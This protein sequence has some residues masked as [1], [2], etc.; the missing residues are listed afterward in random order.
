M[1]AFWLTMLAALAVTA[2][3]VAPAQRSADLRPARADLAD[4]VAGT[5][6]GDVISDA[7]G[8]SR[9]DVT[10]VV[11]KVGANLVEIRSSYSRIPTVRIPLTQAMSAILSNDDDYVF[12]VN[13]D[14]DPRRLDLTI[15]EASR[16][17]MRR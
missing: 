9:S 6:S 4:L 11:T 13:R 12:L 8:S 1:R 7:R 15:D 5:Y 16:S 3:V 10:V 2:P 17:L 14:Q